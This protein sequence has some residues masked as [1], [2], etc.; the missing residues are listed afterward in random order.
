MENLK[1]RKSTQNKG[2]KRVH[3]LFLEY[4]WSPCNGLIVRLSH[5]DALLHSE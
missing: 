2:P 4:G 3:V 1:K 5:M